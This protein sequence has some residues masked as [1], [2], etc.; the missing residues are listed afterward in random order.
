[1]VEK[2]D[3]HRSVRLDSGIG[4]DPDSLRLNGRGITWLRDGALRSAALKGTLPVTGFPV[5]VVV[6]SGLILLLAGTLIKMW[7]PRSSG[8]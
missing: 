3:D 4:V 7:Q 1:V 5:G 8:R 6:I 2:A